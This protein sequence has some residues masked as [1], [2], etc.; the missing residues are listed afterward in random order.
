[1]KGRN[2]MV[3]SGDII[4][5]LAAAILL[6]LITASTAVGLMHET[7]PECDAQFI[8]GEKTCECTCAFSK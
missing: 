8:I 7:S 4:I 1:M 2:N 5:K 3:R 6:M